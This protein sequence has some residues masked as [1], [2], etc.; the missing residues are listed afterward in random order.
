MSKFYSNYHQDKSGKLLASVYE[1]GEKILRKET[2]RPYLFLPKPKNG[3]TIYKSIKGLSLE[4]KEFDT[5]HE[6][7]NFMKTYSDVQGMDVYGSDYFMYQHMYEQYPGEIDY[8]LSLIKTG[9]IDIEVDSNETTGFPDAYRADIPVT[10]ITSSINSV[11]HTFGL[12]EFNQHLFP[13][14]DGLNIHYHK[15]IDEK[16]LLMKFIQYWKHEC[17]DNI[18]GWYVD[19]FDIPYLVN[20]ITKLFSPEYATNLSPWGKIDSREYVAFGKKQIQYTLVGITT[21]DYVDLYK[22]HSYTPQPNY[23]LNTIASYELGVGKLDYSEYGSLANLYKKNPQKYIAYNII[24]AQRVVQLEEKMKLID[25]VCTIAYKAKINFSDTFQTVKPWDIIITNYLLDRNI[26]VPQRAHVGNRSIIGGFVKEPIPNRYNWIVTFDAKSLYPSIIRFLNISPEKMS[27]HFDGISIERILDGLDKDAR[28]YLTSSNKSVSAIGLLFDKDSQGFLAALMKDYFDARVIYK[29]QMIEWQ[30]KKELAVTDEEKRICD[31]NISKF[32]NLQQAIK[33]LI[34]GAYGA[35]ANAGFRFFHPDLAESITSTGQA[36]IKWAER[37]LNT[38]LNK[39]IGT[40]GKDYVILIDT[41][42]VG[43]DLELLVEKFKKPDWD[44]EYTVKWIDKLCEEVFSDYL[45]KAFDEFADIVNA[46]DRE[47]ISFKREVIADTGISIARKRY[48]LNVRNQEGVAYK[49]P[50]LKMT[51]IEAIRSSTPKVIQ[52]YI[53]ET[54]EIIMRGDQSEMQEY[55]KKKREEFEKLPYSE[56]AF[57]RGCNGIIEYS[58][59]SKIYKLGCPIHT[60]AGLV[61]N[62]LLQKESLVNKY[63]PI[64]EGDKIKFCY[65]KMPNPIEHNVIATSDES[66]PVEFNLEGYLDRDLQWEKSFITPLENIINCIG[67][68]VEEKGSLEAFFG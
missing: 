11:Y 16:D 10:L 35:L 17:V 34:N 7:K 65:L 68:S 44:L 55:L 52:D 54:L 49:E 8:D 43:V 4:K 9:F 24:D 25:M 45:K 62:H 38:Y 3:T 14:L 22:K 21:L 23:K 6:A 31:N 41:D 28:E 66:L 39:I 30:K 37:K 40:T 57:P 48:I 36:I 42:S 2:P 5:I 27:G 63:P 61:Y 51:G 47:V 12:H 50:K 20:R 29:N 26:A 15:C 18:S 33:I 13:E 56:I 53:K 67:W 59:S 64:Q 32:K 19:G 58:D 1:N 60:R 46:F